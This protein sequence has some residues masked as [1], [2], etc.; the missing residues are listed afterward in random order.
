VNPRTIPLIAIAVMLACACGQAPPVATSTPP[1]AH[2]Y[3]AGKKGFSVDLPS[4]W[5]P[6]MQEVDGVDFA[7]A[8]RQATVSVRYER[9]NGDL[10]EATRRVVVEL[11]GQSPS[12]LTATGQATLAG[13]PARTF[14]ATISGSKV[15]A[16]QLAAAVTV[17]GDLAWALAL[18]GLRSSFDGART[19]FNQMTH[20]FRLNGASP[21][22][23]ATALVGQPVPDGPALRLA[24]VQGPLVIYFFSSSC[25]PCRSDMPLLQARA[26]AARGRFTVVA[27]DSHDDPSAVPA[28]LKA[29]GFTQPVRYDRDGTMF[30]AYQVLGVPA[31]Y[32]AD[33]GHVLQFIQLDPLDEATLNQGLRSI[34]A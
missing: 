3:D 6:S 5:R 14:E 8:R 27:V 21:S 31:A 2:H 23:V 18:A 22:P 20:S 15:G 10:D 24:Q 26:V 34:G 25:Q 30:Q 13:Y 12:T 9:S 29:I 16:E 33:A 28:F 1:P 17:Q 7:S 32:F 4:S 11:T 19:D